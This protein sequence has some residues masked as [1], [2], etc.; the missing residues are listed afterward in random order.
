M[1]N[2]IGLVIHDLDKVDDVV[3]AWLKAG[4][5]G[6]TLMDSSGLSH[7]MGREGARDDLPI[8]PS[9]RSMLESTGEQNRLL[10]TIVGD[11]F[12]ADGLVRETQAVLGMLEQPGTGI[13]FVMP[14]TRVVGLQ[15]Q[16]RE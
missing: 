7:H 2:L 6:L 13:L 3:H 14:V 9:L 5:S 15:P 10:F 11:G 1:P 4:I 12:D 8:F 16:T